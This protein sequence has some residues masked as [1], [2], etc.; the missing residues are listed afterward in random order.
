MRLP[1]HPLH[2]RLPPLTS[3]TIRPKLF[4]RVQHTQ[5][6]ILTFERQDDS[7]LPTSGLFYSFT[8]IMLNKDVFLI[9][10]NRLLHDHTVTACHPDPKLQHVQVTDNYLD[11]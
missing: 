3:K 6:E 10:N 2:N 11:L 5:H 9:F 7:T 8:K 1:L 4:V